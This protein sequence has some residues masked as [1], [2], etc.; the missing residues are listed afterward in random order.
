MGKVRIPLGRGRARVYDFDAEA[1]AL[2]AAEEVARASK[3]QIAAGAHGSVGSRPR[4][5]RTGKLMRSI[6]PVVEDGSGDHARVTVAVTATDRRDFV[7]AELERGERYVG[8][9]G[10][11]LSRVARAWARKVA[12]GRR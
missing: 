12:R 5:L 11:R 6:R 3:A 7:E 1:L 10:A 2:A 8:K 9:A 4:G